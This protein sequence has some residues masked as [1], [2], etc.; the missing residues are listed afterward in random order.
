MGGKARSRYNTT[1][2]LHSEVR[3]PFIIAY[4]LIGRLQELITIK[5]LPRKFKVTFFTPYN[6]YSAAFNEVYVA[7][8]NSTVY[9]DVTVIDNNNVLQNNL[10][11]VNVSVL[12]PDGSTNSYS[13]T[14]GVANLGGGK[15][16]LIYLTKGAGMNREF[17]TFQ[18]SDGSSLNAFNNVPVTY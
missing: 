17:W 2:P 13:L 1:A 15:Y 7:N 12:F 16:Q 14:N 18:A 6:Q 11:V 3:T 4:A 10:S 8:P 9:S 5:A